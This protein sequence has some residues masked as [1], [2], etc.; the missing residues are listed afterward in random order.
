[1]AKVSPQ[2]L[3]GLPV[4][5]LQPLLVS[6]SAVFSLIGTL[7]LGWRLFNVIERLVDHQLLGIHHVNETMNR[8]SQW[9]WD[10]GFL[11]WGALMILSG[12]CCRA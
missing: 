5:L 7:L 9:A 8:T 1:V 12:W 4:R 3:P 2:A 6:G 11:S 10:A